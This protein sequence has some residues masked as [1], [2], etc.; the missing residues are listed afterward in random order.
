[1][2]KPN[3]MPEKKWLSQFFSNDSI[4]AILEKQCRLKRV[5]VMDKNSQY[6]ERLTTNWEMELQLKKSGVITGRYIVKAR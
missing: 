2:Y 3:R 5:I 1:M 4:T 6:F